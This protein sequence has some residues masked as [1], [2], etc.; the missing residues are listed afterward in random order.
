MNNT[1]KE[2]K[3]NNQSNLR[4]QSHSTI[5]DHAEYCQ[6]NERK[7]HR[8]FR[9]ELSAAVKRSKL[10]LHSTTKLPTKQK[11]KNKHT[12]NKKKKKLVNTRHFRENREI[13]R[14]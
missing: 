14:Q 7:I 2:V 10:L 1:N 13:K 12:P 5:H 6:E 11:F 8:R 3:S 9:P 4:K